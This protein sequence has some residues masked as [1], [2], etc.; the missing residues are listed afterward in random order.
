MKV[1]WAPRALV[2]V[3][4]IAEYIAADRPRAASRWVTALF[5]RVATLRHHPRRGRRVPE[6]INRDN[7]REV[8][9][10]AYRVIYRVEPRRLVVL[11]VR[12][13]RRQWDAA[14][15]EDEL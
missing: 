15:L 12:H 6:A 11:T 10:G 1:I 3:T 5:E 13:G 4:E 2:R 9:H 14:D 7:L 8:V